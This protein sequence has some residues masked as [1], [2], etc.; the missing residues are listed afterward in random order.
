MTAQRSEDQG[1]I[2]GTTLSSRSIRWVLPDL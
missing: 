2:V 1:A